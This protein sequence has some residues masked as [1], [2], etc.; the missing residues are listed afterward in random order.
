[1]CSTSLCF[2]VLLC[3]R[4]CFV[5]FVNI[6]RFRVVML[7]C[8]MESVMQFFNAINILGLI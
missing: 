5:P 3:K 6:G 1:M 8:A 2:V 7:R 4:V